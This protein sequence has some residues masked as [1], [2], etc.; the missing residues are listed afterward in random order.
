MLD[1]LGHMLLE[2]MVVGRHSVRFT[3]GM[4]VVVLPSR[5]LWEEMGHSMS[6][7]QFKNSCFGVI[8]PR[9]STG[10]GFI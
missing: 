8:E 3:V 2:N 9:N 4:P 5:F 1:R 7:K 10:K 6:R